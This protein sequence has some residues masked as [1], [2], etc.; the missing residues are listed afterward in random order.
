M[1]DRTKQDW[2]EDEL[3]QAARLSRSAKEADN[4]LAL[5]DGTDNLIVQV[6]E[7]RIPIT[8]ADPE[9]VD[10][11]T[12]IKSVAARRKAELDTSLGSLGVTLKLNPPVEIPP[13][14]VEIG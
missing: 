10:I 11:V 6:R 12:A 13:G 5:I 8:P 9:W 4:A 3:L 14:D 1:V 7:G 2:N